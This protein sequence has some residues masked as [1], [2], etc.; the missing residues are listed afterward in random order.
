MIKVKEGAKCIII[1]GIH[2]GSQGVI[3]SLQ[4]GTSIKQ[5]SAQV[6]GSDGA[7][8]ETLLKN[9]MIVE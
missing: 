4:A 2:V 5:A 6:Q 9:I 3:K 7:V 8:F 1:D